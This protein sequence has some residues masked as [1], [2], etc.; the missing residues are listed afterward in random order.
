MKCTLF[1][2]YTVSKVTGELNLTSGQC[3]NTCQ[4]T[5]LYLKPMPQRPLIC[6]VRL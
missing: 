1:V 3:Y 6:G 2:V 4:S 5:G